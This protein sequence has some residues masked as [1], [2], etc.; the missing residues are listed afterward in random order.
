MVRAGRS[1][2]SR[3][4]LGL[5]RPSLTSAHTAALTSLIRKMRRRRRRSVPNVDPLDGGAHALVLIL[6]E[7]PGPRAVASG[8]VSMC[9]DDPSARNMKRS[10]IQAGLRRKDVVLWNIVPWC[11]S[12][13]TKNLNA[14][15]GHAR[16]ALCETHEF[17]E[18]LTELRAIV[19]CGGV[20]RAMR[21][22]LKVSVPVYETYHTAQRSY[23]RAR[24][25][26]HIHATLRRVAAS[27]GRDKQPKS[28]NSRQNPA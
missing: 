17:I 10:I 27:L 13:K 3:A 26:Q 14:K 7:T 8:F 9:N 6:L 21:T 4:R 16:D 28:G 15:S 2:L 19:L 22:H 1:H 11:L 23:G 24:Q 18:Q 12:S 25:R 20:A 5:R